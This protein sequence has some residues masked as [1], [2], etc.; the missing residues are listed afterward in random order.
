MFDLL[1]KEVFFIGIEVFCIRQL[2]VVFLCLCV[3]VS[4]LQYNMEPGG[5]IR[6]RIEFKEPWG[7]K[8]RQFCK[9]NHCIVF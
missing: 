8:N 4:F 2:E 5:C 9:I 6:F 1:V 3:Y 7:G